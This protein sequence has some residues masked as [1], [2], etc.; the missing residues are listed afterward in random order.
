MPRERDIQGKVVGHARSIGILARKLNF[1]EGWPDYV[2]LCNGKT[3]FIEFKGPRGVLEPLQVHMAGVLE[4][5]GFMVKVIDTVDEGMAWVEKFSLWAL[6]N[7]DSDVV[8]SPDTKLLEK[9]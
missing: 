7:E 3:M 8:D 2:L 1:G 5:H 6:S 4:S 9:A